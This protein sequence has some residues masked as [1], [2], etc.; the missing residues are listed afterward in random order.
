MHKDTVCCC[1]NVEYKYKLHKSDK[2]A[3]SKFK[4]FSLRGCIEGSQLYR[5]MGVIHV[6]EITY[7]RE[8]NHSKLEKSKPKLYPPQLWPLK[9]ED[10][11]LYKLQ[12][13]FSNAV[14]SLL[15]FIA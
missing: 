13:C 7:Q 9:A 15:L 6:K 1:E 3:I 11:L 2:I 8:R 5:L 14:S 4:I 10:C 12:P